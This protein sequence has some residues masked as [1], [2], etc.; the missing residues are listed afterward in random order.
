MQGALNNGLLTESKRKEL[1]RL[2]IGKVLDESPG[3]K[4][5]STTFSR[6]AL[7]I[8]R[9]FPKEK[10][11]VYFM[12]SVTASGSE[13]KKKVNAS[14]ILYEIYV[15]RRRKLRSIGVLPQSRQAL[16]KL[17]KQNENNPS[18]STTQ[19]IDSK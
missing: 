10:G 19:V 8:E 13:T 7:Q 12:P 18:S 9:I 17:T 1:G 15:N 5:Q 4:I 14:G 6:L 11:Q 3:S 16:N 2:L